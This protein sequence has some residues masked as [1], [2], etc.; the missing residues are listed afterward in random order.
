MDD[1]KKDE[2]MLIQLILMFQ[3]SALQ[4]M[5]K[6]KNPLTDK[7]EQDLPHAQTSIDILDM[8]YRRM[9]SNLSPE[10]EKMFTSVLQDLKLNY[11]DEVSKAKQNTDKQTTI[12]DQ[13]TS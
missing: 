6:I 5:G 9:K 11:V 1:I 7:I 13:K 12:S 3:T 8:L 10:E 2:L 4:H